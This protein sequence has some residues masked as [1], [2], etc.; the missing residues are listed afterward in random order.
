MLGM[1]CMDGRD[2]GY[3]MDITYGIDGYGCYGCQ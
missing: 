2:N 3:A 1:D